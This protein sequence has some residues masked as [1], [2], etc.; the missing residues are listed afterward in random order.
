MLFCN[1]LYMHID[2]FPVI[3]TNQ[4]TEIKLSNLLDPLYNKLAFLRSSYIHKYIQAIS[5]HGD[6]PT[7][8]LCM[9]QERVTVLDRKLLM[10][11]ALDLMDSEEHRP[12]NARTDGLLHIL[13]CC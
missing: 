4:T 10:N 7:V 1:G 3:H 5:T 8:F 2:E 9:R 13:L 6:L 12:P 11:G